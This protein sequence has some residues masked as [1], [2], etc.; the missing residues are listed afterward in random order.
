[1]IEEFSDSN[2]LHTGNHLTWHTAC[3]TNDDDDDDDQLY[4]CVGHSDVVM[5]AVILNDDDV[6]SR[7]RFLQNGEQVS[8]TMHSFCISMVTF[9]FSVLAVCGARRRHWR[10]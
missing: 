2:L 9:S 4:L 1:M 7:L 8:F 3:D 5:G 10:L 6:A